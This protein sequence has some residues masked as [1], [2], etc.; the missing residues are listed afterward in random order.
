MAILVNIGKGPILMYHNTRSHSGQ[1]I[2]QFCISLMAWPSKSP[3]LNL[4][5]YACDELGRLIEAADHLQQNHGAKI[6]IDGSST[7]SS[8]PR[9]QY[10]KPPRSCRVRGGNKRVIRT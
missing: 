7:S 10:A 8:K 2:Q 5:E 6:G 3:D 1:Y 4:I 9:F